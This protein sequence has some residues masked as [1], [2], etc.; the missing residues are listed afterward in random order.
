V[1]A[2]AFAF[3]THDSQ[4]PY[5]VSAAGRQL[6]CAPAAAAAGKSVSNSGV[7][8]DSARSWNSRS[9]AAAAAE[10]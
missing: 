3:A 8:C 4:L 10:K 7:R 1:P 9:A 6:L 2:A 5:I